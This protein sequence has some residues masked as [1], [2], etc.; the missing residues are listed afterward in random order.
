MVTVLAVEIRLKWWFRPYLTLLIFLSRAG[1]I[2]ENEV[3]T[4]SANKVER[5]VYVFSPKGKPKNKF[6]HGSKQKQSDDS[7][8]Q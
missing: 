2:S 8:A 3:L 6:N 4:R 1:L 5:G 7:L